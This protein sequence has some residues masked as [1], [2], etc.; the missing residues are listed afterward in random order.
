[1][2]RLRRATF[3]KEH[4]VFAFERY[5]FRPVGDALLALSVLLSALVAGCAKDSSPPESRGS[6]P[7]GDFSPVIAEVGEVKLTRA[8]FDF[9][10]ENLP[11]V[12][13]A[14]YTGEGWEQRFF[15]KL[16][17][18]IVVSES[19]ARENYDRQREVEWQLDASRRSIL[20]EA[21]TNR[22]FRGDVEISEQEA[23]E[24]YEANLEHFRSLGRAFGH[25]I[26]T[27]SEQ[28]IREAWAEL[29]DEVSFATV[30][31]K[32]S[33]ETTTANDG[34]TIGWFNRDGFVLGLGFNEEFTRLAFEMEPHSLREPVRIGDKWYI[35]KIG[36]RVEDRPLEFEQARE[37]INRLLAPVVARERYESFVR[38][39]KRALG[40]KGFG[41]FQ[42]ESRS[43]DQLYQLAAESRNT[44]AR[45]D[46]Y[47]KL[48]ELYP[49]HER[50]DD[51][52]FMMGFLNSE[53]FGD[54]GA[55]M[56]AFRRLHREYPE[57]EFAEQAEW[58]MQ[59]L[60]GFTGMRGDLAPTDASE[61]ARRL[62]EQQ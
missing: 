29:Q 32:Y 47:E 24:Y 14:R 27:S 5:R 9:R 58:M 7:G 2:L 39:Q 44:A 12:E 15:D 48:V 25:V 13:K 51:A 18:E 42:G 55:A 31:A 43:A 28:R 56:H 6:G 45:L 30:A 54:Q 1:V 36:A 35:I 37:R 19:A 8:Y 61:A 21:Y 53:E 17:E 40:V 34:G 41:E 16:V 4:V 22:N 62:R 60:G 23:R 50:A 46:F 49:D 11:A 10:Y 3:A 20:F 52:L 59:N 57:S 33:E 26:V 38:Q